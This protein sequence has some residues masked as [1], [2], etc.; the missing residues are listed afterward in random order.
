VGVESYGIGVNA[1]ATCSRGWRLEPSSSSQVPSPKSQVSSPKG[2]TL[3]EIMVVVFILGLLAT[4][5]APRI[6]GRTEEARRTKAMADLRAVE[7]A[8][9]LYKLDNSVY[10]T[11]E[12]GLQALVTRPESGT[13]PI[14]WNPDGYL[15]KLPLDPWGHPYLYLSN[16]DRYTLRSLGADGEEGGE[17][18]YADLD[19]HDL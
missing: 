17:G 4:L 18:K 13:V 3:I 7:Q 1:I 14:R 12:Q 6:M 16:G 19:S 15:D 10:P 2:F 8:L 11:T 9:H 5:V